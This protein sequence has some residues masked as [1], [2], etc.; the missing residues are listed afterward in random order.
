[1]LLVANK[2]CNGN[3]AGRRRTGAAAEFVEDRLAKGSV[4]FALTD[5]VTASGLSAI[6]ANN[7]LRRLRTAVARV[8]RSQPF[9][10]IIAAQHRPMGAPPV[11]WWLDDYFHWLGHP[12]YLAL[13]SAAESY[14][15]APQAVQVYQVMTDVPRR[16]VTVGRLHVRF[17][18][19]HGIH[20][21]PVQQPASAYA[22]L[23]VST[24]ESTALDLVRY[25]SRIG[26]FGRALETLVPLLPH[27][28][29]N[30]MKHA[31]DAEGE[32]STAQRLGY[33]LERAGEDRL[34][35]VVHCW[36]PSRTRWVSLG[37]KQSVPAVCQRSE[38]WR[39]V[40][41]EGEL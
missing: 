1:M 12:Y 20:R 27:F 17:F 34:A 41:A 21:T 19:K 7:Q 5:L 13:L 35:K 40:V 32:T 18:V 3:D 4:T 9:F 8:S 6:A 16:E 39:V 36:L 37:F 28:R 10:V 33:L 15:A 22:P 29:G 26:G 38:R 11:E 31:L 2:M 30:K 23:N 14:G 25:A 24:P